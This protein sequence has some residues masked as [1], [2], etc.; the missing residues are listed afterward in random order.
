MIWIN[1]WVRRRVWFRFRGMGRVRG[2]PAPLHM[3]TSRTLDL[4]PTV[5]PT[6]T[7]LECD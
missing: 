3:I 5:S 1:F 7:T 6:L 4:T 2:K